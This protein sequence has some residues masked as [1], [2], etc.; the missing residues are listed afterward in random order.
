LYEV[1]GR[2]YPDPETCASEPWAP[3]AECMLTFVSNVSDGGGPYAVGGMFEPAGSGPY[4]V[5]GAGPYGVAKEAAWPELT[6]DAIVGG[7]ALPLPEVYEPCGNKPTPDPVVGGAYIEP[8][9]ELIPVST[10][11]IEPSDPVLI[12]LS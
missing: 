10:E 1:G 3:A 4:I 12:M 9:T 5:G 8:S 11:S 2:P 6:P 7:S